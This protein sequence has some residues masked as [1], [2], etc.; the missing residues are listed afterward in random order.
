MFRD[1][2]PSTDMGRGRIRVWKLGSSTARFVSFP[3]SADCTC[4][5]SGPS[6]NTTLE[7]IHK[8]SQDPAITSPVAKRVADWLYDPNGHCHTLPAGIPLRDCCDAVRQG[9]DCHVS[10]ALVRVS[11]LRL[12]GLGD[13]LQSE[14]F[15]GV[16]K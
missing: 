12:Q 10:S 15:G 14:D 3:S 13:R 9:N 4:T 7:L 5:Y 11:I 1:S 8:R 2:D 6:S 16:Q